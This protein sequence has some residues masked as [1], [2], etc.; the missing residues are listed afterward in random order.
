MEVKT[1]TIHGYNKNFQD[2]LKNISYSDMIIWARPPEKIHLP[3]A[4]RI[5]ILSK[6]DHI[7]CN[8]PFIKFNKVKN[9]IFIRIKFKK[10]ELSYEPKYN[11][12]KMRNIKMN[13]LYCKYPLILISCYI[14]NLVTQKRVRLYKKSK[15][16][17]LEA[18]NFSCRESTINYIR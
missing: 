4:E 9:G 13:F 8:R 5:F 12:L 7:D 10:G 16:K 11:R 6:K 18:F 14:K 3:P 2:F 1:I 17:K 15:I